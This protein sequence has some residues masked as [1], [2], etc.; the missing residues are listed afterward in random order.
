M[1]KEDVRR[2]VWI[3]DIKEIILNRLF[4]FIYLFQFINKITFCWAD[5]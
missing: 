1:A 4:Y 5:Y 2:N 3:Y